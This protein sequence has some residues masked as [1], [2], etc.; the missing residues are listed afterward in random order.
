MIGSVQIKAIVRD[1]VKNII[2][3]KNEPVLLT[4]QIIIENTHTIG[5]H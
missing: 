2:H 4:I 3:K 5:L 1:I